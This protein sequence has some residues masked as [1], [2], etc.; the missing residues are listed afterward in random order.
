MCLVMFLHAARGHTVSPVCRVRLSLSLS[1]SLSSLTQPHSIP[2]SPGCAVFLVLATWQTAVV[3]SGG[4]SAAAEG[5]GRC[6]R[7]R[8]SGTLDGVIVG[9]LGGSGTRSIHALLGSVGVLQGPTRWSEGHA[10][11]LYAF[12]HWSTALARRNNVPLPPLWHDPGEIFEPNDACATLERDVVAP[13]AGQWRRRWFGGGGMPWG[14]KAPHTMYW[15]PL[16]EEWGLFR[17]TGLRAVLSLRDPR[18]MAADSGNTNQC[19]LVRRRCSRP[20]CARSRD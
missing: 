12:R 11:D 7:L 10:G 8:D 14:F 1:P 18:Y 2:Y 9:G 5:E 19:Q 4:R 20:L 17:N 15:W 13:I 16:F 3:G 6:A